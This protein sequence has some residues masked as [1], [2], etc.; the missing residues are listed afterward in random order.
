MAGVRYEQ[1]DSESTSFLNGDNAEASKPR[2]GHRRA[3][4]P[5]VIPRCLAYTTLIFT[6]VNFVALMAV[7]HIVSLDGKIHEKISGG[8]MTEQTDKTIFPKIPKSMVVFK[9]DKTYNVDPFGP[10]SLEGPWNKLSPKGKGH[11]RVENPSSLGLSGGF[12]LHNDANPDTTS[13]AEEYTIAMFHQL[14][15]L[16][17]VQSKMTRLLEWY[18]ET[19]DKEYLKFV[20]SQENM[21]DDHV[22]HCIDYIRQSIM[23]SGDSTLEKARVG[24]EGE[25]VRGVDGWDVTHQCRDWDTIFRFAEE[26][27]SR[28]ITGI[29]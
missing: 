14:H 27:R 5:L 23:C 21:A 19:N 3:S 10:D 9:P 29:D 8:C 6:L 22:Y 16:A 18:H 4:N 26:Y 24:E 20:L 25:V 13:K 7:L 1:R 28:N 11:I 15:C 2:S 17:A 12:P